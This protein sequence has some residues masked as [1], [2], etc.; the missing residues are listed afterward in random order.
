MVI[1]L[2]LDVVWWLIYRILDL[3][4]TLPS[5]S[6]ELDAFSNWFLGIVSF[7]S[8]FLP[9]GDLIAIFSLWILLVNFHIVKN[10]IFRVWDALP[11][12]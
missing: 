8:Y 2:M 7:V 5:F 10:L 9:L 4:P 11:F 6:L 12:T 1:N 3:F